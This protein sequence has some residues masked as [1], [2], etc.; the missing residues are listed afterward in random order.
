M[1]EKEIKRNTRKG[2]FTVTQLSY[3][4]RPRRR[5]KWA[6][7]A[8]RPHSFALQA[9]AL[10]ENKVYINGTPEL[11]KSPLRIYLDIEGLPDE[12]FH[13]LIGVLIDDGSTQEFHSFWADSKDDQACVVAQ[14]VRHLSNYADYTIYH[15]GNYESKALKA[16]KSLIPDE[17]RQPLAEIQKR[18]VNV[19]SVVNAAI[20]VPA[21]SNTLKD[22]AGFLGFRWTDLGATGIDSIIWRARWEAHQD[23][24]LETRLLRYNHEDCLALKM[25]TDF[26]RSCNRDQTSEEIA[27]L[28]AHPD[29][30]HTTDLRLT[31]GHSHRFCVISFVL[32]ELD[33]VNKCAY[34]DYQ[35]EKVFVRTNKEMRRVNSRKTAG[36][37][38]NLTP[39][40]RIR[41]ECK[42]CPSCSSRR[43]HEG[44]RNSRIIA[45]LKFSTTGVKRWIIRYDAH[46]YHCDR[47]DEAFLPD[48][49]PT[50]KGKYGHGMKS[51]FAYQ[52]IIGGQ[53]A[54]K[55]M[56]GVNEV[57]GL[58]VE[59]SYR[60]F[61]PSLAEYYRD[62]YR[63]ILA[64]LL[65][66]TLLHADET[67][68]AISGKEQKGYVWVL[69]NMQLVYYFYKD[70]RKGLFL[71]EMLKGF[72]GVLVSD[73]FSAYDSIPCPQQKC[74]IHLLR[75]INEDLLRN[76]FDQELRRIVQ[77]FASLFRAI[78]E[79]VDRFGPKRRHLH[80]HKAHALEFIDAVRQ[81]TYSS[82]CA[83]KYQKRFDKYGERLFT[84]M[85]YDGV[86]WNNNNAEHAMKKFAKYRHAADGRFS[87]KSLGSHLGLLSVVQTC[88][89]K[90]LPVLRFLLSK[91]TELTASSMRRAERL[92][93][94]SQGM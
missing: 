85:D 8:S 67:E 44:K 26:I 36:R 76:P 56:R 1:G 58:Y 78:I 45:D 41:L 77:P 19:L 83:I 21:F 93:K 53:E 35:R 75:D 54:I 49:Y 16:L 32:P 65:R 29:V 68:V 11:Q 47:C 14:F 10:R 48:H 94:V 84:F 2:I 30:V 88:E 9:L 72:S 38:G 50:A 81:E 37:N 34:F 27:G 25:V 39:N 3:T 80:K 91:A 15:Y 31:T 66:G 28:P 70:S 69:A 79:T 92:S 5:P 86:L 18:T 87:E 82:E 74:V 13:Y 61:K 51:W 46:W 52:N 17:L 64:E 43:I 12:N 40:R 71:D 33:F 6:R 42:K 90:D 59:A 73:F 89:Y 57:F 62:T 4:F 60:D 22:I 63:G 23:Q 20:Y 55:I 7:A 24:N